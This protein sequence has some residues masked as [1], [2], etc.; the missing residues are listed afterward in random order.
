MCYNSFEAN[1]EFQHN[2]TMRWSGNLIINTKNIFIFNATIK[3]IATR[4]QIL[5]LKCTKIDFGWG[6]AQT[7]LGE[8][9]ALPQ[10]P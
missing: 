9:T 5:R 7:S 3:I 6:S 1:N 4:C 2:R 8:L 10:I